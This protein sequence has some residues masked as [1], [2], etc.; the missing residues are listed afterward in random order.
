MCQ[1]HFEQL[2]MHCRRSF[3]TFHL[4]VQFLS[5]T[6]LTNIQTLK[7]LLFACI[8]M[9]FFHPS[10]PAIHTILYHK[11]ASFSPS[12]LSVC[13]AVGMHVC[14]GVPCN[15]WLSQK[16]TPALPHPSPLTQTHKTLL[17]EKGV[18]GRKREKGIERV[19]D[20]SRRMLILFI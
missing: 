5:K 6:I 18:R 15:S 2:Q 16:Q 8:T 3:S 19:C 1:C 20:A 10:I 14:W 11:P 7:V 12:P 9:H 13:L 4:A 17:G